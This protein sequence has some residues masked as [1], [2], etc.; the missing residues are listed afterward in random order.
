MDLWSWWKFYGTRDHEEKDLEEEF[1]FLAPSISGFTCYYYFQKRYVIKLLGQYRF[2][3]WHDLWQ[4]HVII[5][6]FIFYKKL[7]ISTGTSRSTYGGV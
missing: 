6:L 3:K 1:R 2:T 5:Y 4:V 7:Y